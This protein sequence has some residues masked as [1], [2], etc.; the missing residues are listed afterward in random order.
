MAYTIQKPS[1]SSHI[2]I[3]V[4]DT[5]TTTE[6]DGVSSPEWM[7]RIDDFVESRVTGYEDHT[8]LF[9]WFAKSSRECNGHISSSIPSSATLKH[10][11]VVLMIPNGGHAVQLEMRMNTGTPL[12]LVTVAR[13]GN[14]RTNKVKLQTI[15]FAKCTIKSFQ[16]ELD[17]LI[18]H[19]SVTSKTNTVH[20]YD[21]EGSPKGQMVSRV[22]YSKNTAE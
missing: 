14:V 2:R 4:V 7:V 10:S 21:E 5:P 22:D 20:V 15:D 13:L 8:D 3:P 12:E 19:V 18:L 1:G 9:G 6:E 17:R 11:D 16:Q